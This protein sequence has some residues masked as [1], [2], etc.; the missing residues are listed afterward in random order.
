MYINGLLRNISS[1]LNYVINLKLKRVFPNMLT[2]YSDYVVLHSG[3]QSVHAETATSINNST[4]IRSQTEFIPHLG[5]F[6]VTTNRH[7]VP[8]SSHQSSNSES[9]SVIQLVDNLFAF[10]GTLKC[11]SVCTRTNRRTVHPK[12]LETNYAP[13]YP[14]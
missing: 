14:I 1:D 6:A 7:C 9:H 5:T 10:R 11:I 12:P 3:R 2:F 4:R 8:L 13:P